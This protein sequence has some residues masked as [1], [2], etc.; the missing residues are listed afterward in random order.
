MPQG[1]GHASDFPG[2]ACRTRIPGHT[3]SS[4]AQVWIMQPPYSPRSARLSAGIVVSFTMRVVW[5]RLR[6]PLMAAVSPLDTEVTEQVRGE[7]KQACLR[8]MFRRA[9]GDVVYLLDADTRLSS[10]V[11]AATVRPVLA[12]AAAAT[13]MNRPLEHQLRDPR[14]V[15]QWVHMLKAWMLAGPTLAEICG[16]NAALRADV[17]R[18][19]G[20]FDAEAPIGTDYTLSL[21]LAHAGHEIVHVR[22]ALVETDYPGIRAYARRMSR[23][24]R[25]HAL[26]GGQA[27]RRAQ[28]R[29][30]LLNAA[31]WV[32][33]AAMTLTY[34]FLA[35]LSSVALAVYSISAHPG[36]FVCRKL[37]AA[38]LRVGSLALATLA[39]Q[40]APLRASWE[41]LWGR[42]RAGW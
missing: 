14:A 33:F 32:C 42:R 24:E 28:R 18:D 12:G 41:L 37:H 7:G 22:E 6:S 16:Q 38:Q 27:A 31:W 3:S 5:G 26:L 39:L 21:L 13:T 40:S 4:S 9:T 19:I 8:A 36:V 11:F 35:P 25:A 29:G 1:P 23:A 10:S 15:A 20:G 34:P 17:L 30:A 2:A